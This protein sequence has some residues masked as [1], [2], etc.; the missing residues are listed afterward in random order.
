MD[1]ERL[2][3]PEEIRAVSGLPPTSSSSSG[4]TETEYLGQAGYINRSSGWA[5]AEGAMKTMMQRIFSHR[6]HINLRRGKAARLLVSHT[7]QKSKAFVSG[8]QLTEG[9]QLNAGLTILATGAWT[10]SLL[11]LTGRIQPTAQCLAYLPLTTTEAAALAKMPVLLNLSTGYFVI[12]PAENAS[13]P[14]STQSPSQPTSTSS[15]DEHYTHHLKVACHAHGYLT[16]TP[17]PCPMP[18]PALTG[19][20][21][22]LSSLF[23]PSSPLA[24]RPFSSSRLCHYTDTPTGD[25]LITYHPKLENLFLCTGGSGHGFKFLPVLGREV[26]SILEGRGGMW[27]AI[28]GWKDKKEEGEWRGDGS[29]GG[30][31]GLRLDEALQKGE[32]SKL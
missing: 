9:S 3:G 14:S 10:P 30:E 13:S 22:F 16:P 31:R 2:K 24:T 12:P 29:R 23:P 17:A 20:R 6:P 19:L 32:R 7:S 25:F 1:V 15:P 11:D 4:G 27:E 28:W 5:N 8:I 18:P 21:T 26:L